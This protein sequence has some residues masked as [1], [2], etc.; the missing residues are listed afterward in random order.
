ME[1]VLDFVKS[2]ARIPQ[3]WCLISQS[4]VVWLVLIFCKFCPGQARYPTQ[5]PKSLSGWCSNSSNLVLEFVQS[6]ARI[7]QIW[8]SNSSNLMLEFVKSGA[9]FRQI[10]CSNSSNM[11]L[12]LVQSGARI[13]QIRCSISSNLVLNFVKSGASCGGPWN[14]SI[15]VL[16]FVKSG[17]RI[18]QITPP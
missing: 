14:S 15:L 17:A 11:V 12:K 13:R 9:R 7:R 8:C 2:G 10:W 5:T 18:R 4:P 6:D 1:V 3:I 16:E